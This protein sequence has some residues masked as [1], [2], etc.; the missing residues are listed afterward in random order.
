MNLEQFVKAM[1]KS[2]KPRLAKVDRVVLPTPDCPLPD[3][4]PDMT[5]NEWVTLCC[6]VH[7]LQ[8]NK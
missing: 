1:H 4:T 8:A 3:H 6:L 7:G 5:N 2:P